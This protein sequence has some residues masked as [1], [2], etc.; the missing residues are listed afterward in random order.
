MM[1]SCEAMSM[2]RIFP[3]ENALHKSGKR[4]PDPTR[5][6]YLHVR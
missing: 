6:Y 4:E 5:R 3:Q 2:G 1:T